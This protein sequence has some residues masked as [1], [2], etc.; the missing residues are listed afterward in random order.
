M[1]ELGENFSKGKVFLKSQS[2]W[3][4]VTEILENILEGINSRSEDAEEQSN[5]KDRVVE[6]TQAKQ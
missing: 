5:L 4:T 2:E 6:T 1:D 3:N